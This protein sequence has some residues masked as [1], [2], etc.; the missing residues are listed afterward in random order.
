MSGK[1]SDSSSRLTTVTQTGFSLSFY[2]IYNRYNP[3]FIS[4]IS[5][6]KLDV[7]LP[8]SSMFGFPILST[9]FDL[10]QDLP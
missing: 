10:Q 6:L 5:R 1:M 2:T 4:A 9:A 3:G 7:K 8:E